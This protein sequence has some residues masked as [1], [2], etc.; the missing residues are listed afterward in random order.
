[1][2]DFYKDF[3]KLLDQDPIYLKSFEPYDFSKL[4]GQLAVSVLWLDNTSQMLTTKSTS[5][6]VNESHDFIDEEE[7]FYFIEFL[8]EL[9]L[10]NY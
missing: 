7:Y 2:E 3:L 6:N 10:E 1:M 9:E 5:S 4:T 8:E